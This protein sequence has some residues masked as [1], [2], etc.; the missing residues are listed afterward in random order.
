M[1]EPWSIRRNASHKSFIKGDVKRRITHGLI[2]PLTTRNQIVNTLGVSTSTAF[3]SRMEV[4]LTALQTQ[5]SS[6][7][8]ETS[9]ITIWWRR[10][11]PLSPNWER[12]GMSHTSLSKTV[13][14]VLQQIEINPTP[15]H[16]KWYSYHLA[17]KFQSIIHVAANL[18]VIMKESHCKIIY[19]KGP[20]HWP[21]LAFDK[22]PTNQAKKPIV[23]TVSLHALYLN[24]YRRNFTRICRW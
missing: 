1:K 13:P 11:T 6:P 22:S 14:P 21:F 7:T 8:P 15:P 23:Y 12:F 19:G 18:N 4:C 10:Q 9:F 17:V 16:T 3:D 5:V 20:L 2:E 24:A